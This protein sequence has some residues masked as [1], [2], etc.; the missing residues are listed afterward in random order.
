ML[1]RHGE[2]YPTK[3]AGSRHLALV[4]RL[5]RLDIPLN[6][7]LSFFNDGWAYFTDNPEQDFEQLTSTGPYAG[8]LG[9]FT[10]GVRFRTRYG[11]LLPKPGL[12]M[13]LWASDSKR[14]IDTARYFAAGLFGISIDW[15]R[16]D[17]AEVDVIPETLDRGTDTLTPGG[18]CVRY[19]ED[20][21]HGHDHGRNMLAE[22]QTAYIPPIARR[23]I[24]EEMNQ[25]V[26]EFTTLE[27]YAMQEMCGFETLARGSS[28]W[29]GVFTSRDWDHFEYARDLIHFYRAGPGNRY[30]GA[31]G[32][33]WLNATSHLLEAGPDL[34]TMFFSFV[35]DGDIAPMLTALH[36][37]DDPKYG[38]HLPVTHI[39]EDRVW[40]TSTVM[41]MGGRIT[42]ERLRCGES[43]EGQD[44]FVRINI[45]DDI[46]PLPNCHNGP[47][48]SCPLDR[49]VKMVHKRRHQVGRFEDVCGTK[50]Q[51]TTGLS[52]LRQ[53]SYHSLEDL[54]SFPSNLCSGGDL[55]QK[56]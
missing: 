24:D 53:P 43:I 4:E 38:N 17:I 42:F 27:I 1:S 35:H 36:I 49:F 20:V 13:R 48:E 54:R 32:W 6:G 14:V 51:E 21:V 44:L 18:T 39:A 3:T 29:C 28:P 10:T 31:M 34:G 22:F 37:F 11:H 55:H 15:E 26:G 16:N 46:V 8:T 5:K 12:K 19:I 56:L 23:L 50:E 33:L 25:V 45:N 2:R 9:S 47:G 41:P 30:A 40:K 52:F 7:S